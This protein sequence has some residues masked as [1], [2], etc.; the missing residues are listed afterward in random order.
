MHEQGQ[1]IRRVLP[2]PDRGRKAEPGWGLV[3]YLGGNQDAIAVASF[4]IIALLASLLLAT[5]F[6]WP[7]DITEALLTLS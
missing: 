4:A 1:W 2:A 7:A 3:S 6:S 5:A